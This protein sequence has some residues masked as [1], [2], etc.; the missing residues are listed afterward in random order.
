M[1]CLYGGYNLHRF[2]DALG[3]VGISRTELFLS[4]SSQS[5]KEKKRGGGGGVA[6]PGTLGAVLASLLTRPEIT[7]LFIEFLL[8]LR[9]LPSFH[10]VVILAIVC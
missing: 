3:L 9:K 7:C 4:S 5:R 2:S 1:H 6:L 10:W 8:G